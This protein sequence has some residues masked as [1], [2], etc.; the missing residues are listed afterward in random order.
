MVLVGDNTIKREMRERVR[1]GKGSP[2]SY[3]ERRMWNLEN[4]LGG[5]RSKVPLTYGE[6][7]TYQLNK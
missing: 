3:W 6:R 1:M 2:V 4:I 5:P 7:E